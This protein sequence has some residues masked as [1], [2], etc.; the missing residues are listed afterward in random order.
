MAKQENESEIAKMNWGR[1]REVLRKPPTRGDSVSPQEK[2][3]RDYFGEELFRDLR[4]LSEP[5]RASETKKELGNVIV[6]PGVMGSHLSVVEPGGD[7]DHVWV[8]LWRLV[9]GDMKRLKLSSDGKTNVNGETVRATSLIGWYYA[10]ALETLQAEPFPYDWRVSVCDTADRLKE[11]VE[12]NLADGTFD[13]NKPVHFVAHSMG[14]LVVRNFVRQHPDWWNKVQGRLV[15]LGTP[16]AGSFAAVQT[17]MGKNSLVKNIAAVLP[18]Q[19]KSDW[20][21]VVNSFP[22]LYQLCP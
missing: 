20:F 10:L 12:E 5:K 18:F 17:L 14:G 3:L 9:K 2:N 8:S 16:N 4:E 13:P 21:Q 19:S 22:G 15:M 7:E 6:L 11:F 1:V